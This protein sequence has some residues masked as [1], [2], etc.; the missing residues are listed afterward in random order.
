MMQTSTFFTTKTSIMRLIAAI[1]YSVACVFTTAS[2]AVAD[3]PVSLM[4]AISQWSYPKSKMSGAEMSDAATVN[5]D[6]K[7]TAQSFVCKTTMT[8]DDSVEE[9]LAFYKTK[10]T[11]DKNADDKTK[12]NL[13]DG[14]SV[15]MSDD[16]EGRPFALH[17]ILVNTATTSTTLIV[18]RGNGE[19][20]THITWKHY[21]RL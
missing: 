9:V 2:T 21:V 13:K 18:S 20:E 11:P 4:R 17:T 14:R 10:L 7:R 12:A 1:L 3:E 6:G 19:T 5:G 15:L 16:S 8:T